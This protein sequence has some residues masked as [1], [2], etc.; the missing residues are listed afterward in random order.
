[1][2]SNGEG[3]VIYKQKVNG[4]CLPNPSGQPQKPT[5]LNGSH[6]NML[7]IIIPCTVIGNDK[8][9][10]ILFKFMLRNV[11]IGASL[12][13]ILSTSG[14]AYFTALHILGLTLWH[15]EIPSWPTSDWEKFQYENA[16]T[17]QSVNPM[18]TSAKSSNVLWHSFVSS[19]G[20]AFEWISAHTFLTIQTITFKPAIC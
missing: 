11:D 19:C 6:K 20:S 10:M 8:R 15:S 5:F 13:A 17:H 16:P 3:Y 9:T 4:K 7:I 1:M 14:A 2:L 18:H 12:Q